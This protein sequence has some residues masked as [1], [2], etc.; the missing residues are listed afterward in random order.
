MKNFIFIA[1]QSLLCRHIFKRFDKKIIE[2]AM[3]NLINYFK[4][5]IRIIKV[6]C[7]FKNKKHELNCT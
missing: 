1:F 5:I 4:Y 3:R 2:I 6:Y 7:G